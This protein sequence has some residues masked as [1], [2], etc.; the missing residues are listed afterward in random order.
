MQRTL[1]L[2]PIFV[3]LSGLTECVSFHEQALKPE[4]TAKDFSSRSLENKG[5][6][7]FLATQN[8]AH[9][10]WSPDRL[11]LVGTYFHADIAVAKAE[12]QEAAARI[13]AAGQRPNPVLSF[14]PGYNS[15]TSGISPWIIT[16]TLDV[17]IETAGRRNIRVDQARA[18]VEAS[19]LRVDAVAWKV[20]KE[21]RSSM[22]DLY[23]AR[24][25]SQLLTIQ[26]QLHQDE[27]KKLQVMVAAGESAAF[28]LNQARLSLNEAQLAQHDA[29]KL[30]ATALAQLAS[31]IGVP[32]AAIDPAKLDFSTFKTLP[33]DPGKWAQR[34]A[35]TTRADLLAALADYAASDAALRLE[36]ARQ[37]PNLHLNPGYELDQTDNKW[38]LGFSLELPIL[39]Q[40]RGPIAEADAKR[41]KAAKI[42]E[43]KQRAVFGEIEIAL[44]AHRTTRAKVE[45]ASRLAKE[46]AHA[47]DTTRGMVESGELAPLELTRR[48]IE[49]SAATLGLEKALIEAQQAA[50]DLEAAVQI[51]AQKA[52]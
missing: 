28:E 19:R 50:G 20:R 42:F 24:Q 49:T 40:N 7:S 12:Q 22:L 37:Y 29:E 36:I 17:P 26:N 2:L 9:G 34:Q 21:I 38:S 51:P 33:S 27:L 6:Q 41:K 5:L 1:L 47:S 45:T 35:L 3:A 48:R 15:T 30:K 11:A 32:S 23:A 10:T 44:A 25:I 31:A 14:S 16:P 43:A 18:E 46:A 39:N 52:N 13:T 4:T 8:A